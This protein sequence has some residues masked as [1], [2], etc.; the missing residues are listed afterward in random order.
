MSHS[1]VNEACELSILGG[2]QPSRTAQAPAAA[3]ITLSLAPRGGLSGL[4]RHEADAARG[5]DVSRSWQA[6][7]L[8]RSSGS[9]RRRTLPAAAAPQQSRP[10]QVSRLL[11]SRPL[12]SH[13]PPTKQRT[14]QGWRRLQRGSARA[15][16][17]RTQRRAQGPTA[18]RQPAACWAASRSLRR[19]S[20]ASA[21]CR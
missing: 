9:S 8:A 13:T 10:W 5:A 7:P 15:A 11:H 18:Q 19:S 20:L 6:R 1:D 17:S 3:F 12:R 21:G 4:V 2:L 16:C 14:L